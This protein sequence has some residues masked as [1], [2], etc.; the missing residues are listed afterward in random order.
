MQF[1]FFVQALSVSYILSRVV[2][3]E[4]VAFV[5]ALATLLGVER[6]FVE[7]HSTLL[8]CG[9]L[10]NECTLSPES[11]HGAYCLFKLW[12]GHTMSQAWKPTHNQ[13]VKIKRNSKGVICTIV[14]V[15]I[16][17]VLVFGAVISGSDTFVSELFNGVDVQHDVVFIPRAFTLRFQL[18]A[19][20]FLIRL[21]FS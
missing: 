16:W 14:A 2:F 4:H 12:E 19:Q 20:T 17:S 18:C 3:S 8:T 11:Q 15:I 21:I 7:Q 1:G 6:G 10:I 13:I 5:K 9:H